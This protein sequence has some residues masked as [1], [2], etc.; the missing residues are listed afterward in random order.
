MYNINLANNKQHQS[1]SNKN[2]VQ[3]LAVVV[4]LNIA[5]ML[6]YHLFFSQTGEQSYTMT[7][8]GFYTLFS[9]PLLTMCIVAIA[10][11]LVQSSAKLQISIRVRSFLKGLSLLSISCYLLFMGTHFLIGLPI[12][13]EGTSAIFLPFLFIGLFLSIG[14]YKE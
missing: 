11:I 4:V 3:V 12:N 1:Q 13:I 2:L 8:R 5:Y 6:G 9:M 7:H 10:G 14:F